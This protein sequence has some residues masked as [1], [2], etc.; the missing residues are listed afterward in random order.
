MGNYARRGWA[1]NEIWATKL[2]PFGEAQVMWLTHGHLYYPTR[3]SATFRLADPTQNIQPFDIVLVVLPPRSMADELTYLVES[4]RGLRF[5]DRMTGLSE[6]D[7]HGPKTSHI[8]LLKEART[9][10]QSAEATTSAAQQF[11]SLAESKHAQRDEDIARLSCLKRKANA[12][13][14]IAESFSDAVER[15]IVGYLTSLAGLGTVE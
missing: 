10:I 12:L 4:A 7:S 15:Y 2:V 11:V 14:S 9:L 1:L 13:A 3:Y 6:S 8:A 5:A